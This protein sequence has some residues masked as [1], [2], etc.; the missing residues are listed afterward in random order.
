MNGKGKLLMLCTCR[1]H[2][3]PRDNGVQRQTGREV[4]RIYR[5]FTPKLVDTVG[6]GFF[7]VFR[8]PLFDFGFDPLHG[9]LLPPDWIRRDRNWRPCVQGYYTVHQTQSSTEKFVACASKRTGNHWLVSV[10]FI[11]LF[12][13]TDIQLCLPSGCVPRGE[14]HC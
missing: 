13:E 7:S 3:S 4:L 2:K 5:T 14:D 1:V 10:L 6:R 12:G 11:V 9:Q 8:N